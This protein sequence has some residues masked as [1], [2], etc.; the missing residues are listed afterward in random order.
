MSSPD[1]DEADRNSAERTEKQSGLIRV[2]EPTGSSGIPDQG[3]MGEESH[4]AER[5]PEQPGTLIVL[6]ELET[7]VDA[8]E[9]ENTRLRTDYASPKVVVPQNCAGTRSH[10]TLAVLGGIGCRMSVRFCSSPAR[11]GCS[12][13]R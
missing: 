4:S 12:A 1:S 13:R 11:S 7:V 5:Q 2:R 10:R 8:L 3:S 6:K 9:A